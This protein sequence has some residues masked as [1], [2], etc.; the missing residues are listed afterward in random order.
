MGWA[1]DMDLKRRASIPPKNEVRRMLV[2]CETT[3]KLTDTLRTIEVGAFA[4]VRLGRNKFV[5]AH[6]GKTHYW[7]AKD[8]V[9]A[10]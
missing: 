5:C 1:K 9:L 3:A 8:V 7:T 6:C 4:T 10:R 2:R